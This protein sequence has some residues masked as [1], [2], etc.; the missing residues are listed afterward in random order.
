MRKIT[1]KVIGILALI[2][3]AIG[4]ILCLFSGEFKISTVL[5]TTGGT[6]ILG[7]FG[8]GTE[9]GNV[10]SPITNSA[11]YNTDLATGKLITELQKLNKK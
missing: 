9:T 4:L 8:E 7:L 11:I 10:S 2:G 1:L 3:A 6:L 5:I